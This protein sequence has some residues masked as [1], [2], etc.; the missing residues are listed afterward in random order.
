MNRTSHVSITELLAHAPWLLRLAQT[1]V[2]DRA[3]ADDLVQETWL[4]ALN[5]PPAP[6]PVRPWLRGVMTRLALMKKRSSGRRVQWEERGA[7]REAIVSAAHIVEEEELRRLV[8]DQVLQLEEPYRATILLRYRDGMRAVEIAALDGIPTSTVRSRLK[9]GLAELRTRLDAS[10]PRDWHTGLLVMLAERGIVPVSM[11]HTTA[12]LAAAA[13]LCAGFLTLAVALTSHDESHRSGDSLDMGPSNLV[14]NG[15]SGAADLASSPVGER[16]V[17]E[18]EHPLPETLEGRVLD[19]QT[20]EP[21][22]ATLLL[23]L[24]ET[25]RGLQPAAFRNDAD[26]WFRVPR[27]ERRQ[28]VAHAAGYVPNGVVIDQGTHLPIVLRLVRDE[29]TFE[30]VLRLEDSE[31]RPVPRG[32]VFLVDYEPRPAEDADFATPLRPRFFASEPST[33]LRAVFGGRESSLVQAD[34]KWHRASATAFPGVYRIWAMDAG[35]YIAWYQDRD[36]APQRIATLDVRP[37]DE[38]LIARLAPRAVLQGRVLGSREPLDVLCVRRD[39]LGIANV[40]R[41]RVPVGED[42]S[43]SIRGLEPGRAHDLLLARAG[44]T[45]PGATNIVPSLEEQASP[46]VVLD[47]STLPEAAP[48]VAV[49]TVV[50][51]SSGAPL[52]GAMLRHALGEAHADDAGRFALTTRSERPFDWPVDR[53]YRDEVLTVDVTCAGYH[54]RRASRPL[55]A[56]GVRIEL[57]P[58]AEERLVRDGRFTRLEVEVVPDRT[59]LPGDLRLVVQE[60]GDE[61]RADPLPNEWPDARATYRDAVRS[62]HL[63]TAFFEC[64]ATGWRG[65]LPSPQVLSRPA[66]RIGGRIEVDVLRERSLGE[67]PRDVH[68]ALPERLRVTCWSDAHGLAGSV[69]VTPRLGGVTPARVILAPMPRMTFQLTDRAGRP[70]DPDAFFVSLSRP[71]HHA[72]LHEEDDATYRVDAMWPGTYRLLVVPRDADRRVLLERETF[73]LQSGDVRH[74]TVRAVLVH[75]RS[76]VDAR[77][78]AVCLPPPL[79]GTSLLYLRAEDWLPQSVTL[80]LPNPAHGARHRYDPISGAT[81]EL[82]GEEEPWRMRCD[83]PSFEVFGRAWRPRLE[84]HAEPAFFV[85]AT[86]RSTHYVIGI[87]EGEPAR[88]E[89]THDAR[90]G[91]RERITI[92]R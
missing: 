20:G 67:E 4:A 32:D 53:A 48:F 89:I 43:F 58:N 25:Y 64:T 88:V 52:P 33:L 1:L 45:F 68:I 22:V 69:V 18:P 55:L 66:L 15:G 6:G 61:I 57:Y 72:L 49:G 81:L 91:W 50:D 30:R 39:A 13:I 26:G 8:I 83:P 7:R 11:R 47:A 59:P 46:I 65:W 70:L 10:S 73:T 27:G 54:D 35:R 21:V 40:V 80:R 2:E 56:Q 87:P 51:A 90:P 60:E 38:P 19:A 71:G 23:G 31:G 3:S 76:V 24:F 44:E 37:G 78:E 16:F 36:H 42:G 92:G 34:G 84:V 17:E 75:F 86:V 12:W 29:A 9:R 63:N 85:G 14:A 41:A 5:K 77:G 82:A 79:A 74:E 28:L 62:P